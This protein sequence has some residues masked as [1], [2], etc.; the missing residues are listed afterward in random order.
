MIT[1]LFATFNDVSSRPPRLIRTT[2]GYFYLVCFNCGDRIDGYIVWNDEV[3]GVRQ[4]CSPEE[5]YDR[6]EQSK[7]KK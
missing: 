7:D 1:T 3:Y 6:Y 4:I 5:F 2:G